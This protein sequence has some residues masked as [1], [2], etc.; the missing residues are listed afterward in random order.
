MFR[1]CC[2]RSTRVN[3]L[4]DGEIIAFAKT[5]YEQR[6]T[7]EYI[8]LGCRRSRGTK[9]DEICYVLDGKRVGLCRKT[10]SPPDVDRRVSARM[11]NTQPDKRTEIPGFSISTC[12]YM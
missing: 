1:P 6:E 4:N 5:C 11:P 8:V 2:A 7:R 12:P 9:S 10:P 3:V